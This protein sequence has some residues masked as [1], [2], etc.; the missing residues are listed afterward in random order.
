[1]KRALFLNL[2]NRQRI[3]R[4]YMC[5]YKSPTFLFQPIELLSLAAIY[6]GWNCGDPVLID[7]IAENI[8]QPELHQ[9]IKTIAPEFIISI[10]GFECFEEDM[11]AIDEIKS[12]FPDTPFILFGHYATVFAEETLENINVDYVIH[13]EPDIV[14]SE[15][16]NAMEGK[17]EYETIKG[18]SYRKH[19]VPIHQKG[20]SRIPDPNELPIPAF[21]LL[22]N[23]LYGE[24]FFPKPY[25]LIQ[26]ARGC[27]YQCNYCIKSFGK[28]LTALSPENMVAQV[29]EYIDLFDIKSFRF[30]DDTFTAVPKRV[31]E[32]CKLLI[33]RGINLKWSCLT[34]PDTLDK[35][36]LEWMKKSGCSR[37]YIGMESGSQ[38]ILD[39]YSRNIK[40]N[41][42]LENIKYCKSIGFEVMGFFIVGAPIETKEDVDKSI[43]FALKADFNF[44]TIGE[45]IAYP[46][47]LLYERM[48]DDVEFSIFPYVNKFKD[49]RLN[50]NAY[51][52][53]RYF[54]RKFYFNYKTIIK[55]INDNVFVNHKDLLNNT[56]A[57]L[58]YIGSSTRQQVRK[59]FF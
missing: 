19:G 32:F 51:K 16:L 42:A 22:K 12:E 48:K 25:G 26:S 3:M 44:I 7:A 28:K 56:Y 27:P 40:V 29:Q 59:D 24:P 21:D 53:Q 13:G 47:T 37:L 52:F 15:L 4:R 33:E 30:I 2:P 43:D 45:L 41:E 36:M 17:I 6:R 11:A 14:F 58:N 9:K 35:E 1:M 50:E 57:F 38:R 5:S 46:G 34:R 20:V 55:T 8:E 54:F 31:I 49:E 10:C 23:Q 39:F 18:I